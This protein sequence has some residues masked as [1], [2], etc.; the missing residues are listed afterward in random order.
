MDIL[1][2]I[3]YLV[4]GLGAGVVTGLAGLSAAV[5]ITPLL[6]SACGWDSYNATTVALATDVLASMLTAVTYAKN[7]NI[8]VKSGLLVGLTALIGTVV[9]SYC[10]YLFN[11]SQ[12]GGLGLIAMATTVFLGIKF[13]IKPINGGVGGSDGTQAEIG[14]KK[15]ALA[16]LCGLFIGWVCGFTGS[17]GGVLML[18]VFTLLIGYN[19]KVAVGT[20]TMIMTSVAFVGAISHI[21]MGANVDLM[22]MVIVVASCLVGALIA[23]KFANKCD[24]EKLNRVIG[25]VL[26]ILGIVTIMIKK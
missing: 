19:L 14:S 26:I 7:K 11:Q 17:G 22:A 16:M 12:P 13:L 9:G 1:N 21:S 6:V 2:L 8:D 15:M 25:F 4:A 3:V 10:G 24:I 18:T 5:V 23:A 20:S